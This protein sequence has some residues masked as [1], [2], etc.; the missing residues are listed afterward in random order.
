MDK[1][2]ERDQKLSEP[3]DRGDALQA[4]ASRFETNAAELKRQYWWKNQ[5]TRAK[6]TVLV[7]ATIITIVLWNVS[8]R[9]TSETPAC[10]SEPLQTILEPVTLSS[11]LTVVSKVIILLL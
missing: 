4:G 9:R 11:S 5:K 2:L 7:A 6:D 1:G 3:E 8:L 10:C